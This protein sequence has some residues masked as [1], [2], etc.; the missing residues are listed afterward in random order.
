MGVRV[1]VTSPRHALFDN[2][3]GHKWHTRSPAAPGEARTSARKSRGIAIPRGIRDEAR[4]ADAARRA[5]ITHSGPVYLA[6]CR[7]N[8]TK[9]TRTVK[10][11]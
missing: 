7:V 11:R 10:S 2:R 3:T 5:R 4:S 8:R 1:S 9:M 6:L